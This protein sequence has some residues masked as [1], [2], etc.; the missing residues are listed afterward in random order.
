MLPDMKQPEDVAPPGFFKDRIINNPVTTISGVG[1]A[2]GSALISLI[3]PDG[4]VSTGTAIIA[5]GT[6]LMGLF[7][8]DK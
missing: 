1:F 7:A 5:L 2:I 4:K 8:K 6:L 3:G